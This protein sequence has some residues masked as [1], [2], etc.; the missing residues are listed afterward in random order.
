LLSKLS[1][2]GR[3][4]AII[5]ISPF[6]WLNY[7]ISYHRSQNIPLIWFIELQYSTQRLTYNKNNEAKNFNFRLR[8]CP[9]LTNFYLVI[10][11]IKISKGMIY[12]IILMANAFWCFLI[13][14][15]LPKKQPMSEYLGGKKH[16]KTLFFIKEK[17]TM[18]KVKGGNV[19]HW[20]CSSWMTKVSENDQHI[21][22]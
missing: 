6:F 10:F 3:K 21:W 9:V 16:V 14:Y 5:N 15:H 13:C 11:F 12:Q 19:N 22:T 1:H 8:A 4:K 17:K 18:T 7:I 20:A 2:Q